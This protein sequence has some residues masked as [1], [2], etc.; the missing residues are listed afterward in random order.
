[1][2]SRKF[3]LQNPHLVAIIF[4]FMTS[5]DVIQ[6]ICAAEIV[7]DVRAEVNTDPSFARR[8]TWLRLRVGPQEF[9]HEA[10]VR[11]L[12]VPGDLPQLFYCDVV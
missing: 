1:M 6:V 3:L 10:A 2:L 8:P 7:G 4:H 11:R 9:T 5:H 12:A